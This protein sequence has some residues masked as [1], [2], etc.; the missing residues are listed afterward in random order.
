MFLS[1]AIP[2]RNKIK[3]FTTYDGRVIDIEAGYEHTIFALDD[4]T[5]QGCGSAWNWALGVSSPPPTTNTAYSRPNPYVGWRVNTTF[6]S[7][8]SYYRPTPCSVNP[9]EDYDY[10]DISFSTGD[11]LKID[12][13]KPKQI[14]AGFSNTLI[15]NGNNRVV[16]GCGANDRGQTNP[17]S[18]EVPV[19]TFAP[20]SASN[21]VVLTAVAVETNRHS[22]FL[23]EDGTVLSCGNNANGEL[24]NQYT[25][26]ARSNRLDRVGTLGLG[27]LVDPQQLAI[28]SKGN[29]Y[30][31]DWGDISIKKLTPSGIMY[32]YAGDASLDMSVQTAQVI[33]RTAKRFATPVGLVIDSFDNIYVSEYSGQ[34]IRK[35]TPAGTVSLYAGSAGASGSTDNTNGVF[36]T[37]FTPFHLAMHSSGEIYVADC[38]NQAIRKISLATGVFK[39]AG[40][41]RHSGRTDGSRNDSTFQFP[42]GII[43]DSSENI[44]VADTGNHSIRKITAAGV[45][46]TLAGTSTLSGTQDG[47]GGNARFFNPEGI[48]ID[49]SGNLYVAD[50]GNHT[51]RKITSEGVVTTFA[52]MSGVR[53]YQ[54]GTGSAARF[55]EPRGITIDSA[56]NLYV[57]DGFPSIRKITTTGVVTTLW[58]SSTTIPSKDNNTLTDVT[59]MAAGSAHS[60]FLKADGTVWSCGSN[61]GGQLGV[62]G[63]AGGQVVQVQAATRQLVKPVGIVL[64]EDGCGYVIDQTA[65]KLAKIWTDG[66]M[67]TLADIANPQNICIDL[68][69]TIFVGCSNGVIKRITP[70][71]AVTDIATTNL[72]NIG[73]GAMVVDSSANV[74]YLA[75]DTEHVIRKINGFTGSVEILAGQLNT[76]GST[77]GT[78]TSA[79]FNTPYGLALDENRNLYVGDSGNKMVRKINTST[80]QVTTF[81]SN[82]YYAVNVGP[83]Q[84][85][86]EWFYLTIDKNSLVMTTSRHE[87][88]SSSGLQVR[89][90]TIWEWGLD[91]RYI[92]FGMIPGTARF[93]RPTGITID[94]SSNLYIVEQF[95]NTIRKITPEGAVTTFAGASSTGG[96]DGTGNQA[97]FFNPNGITKDSS[98]NLYIADVNNHAIR[99]ITPAGVVTTFAG[100]V[101][102]GGTRNG[103]GTNARFISPFA[104]VADSSDNIFVCENAV[105]TIRRIT[106]AGVVTTFAGLSGSSGNVVGAGSTARFN[107]PMGI[108]IDSSGNLYVA[109]RTN[110]AIKKI[111]SAGVVS[112][113][114]GS[115]T[116]QTGST[117]GTGSAARFNEPTAIAIDSSGNI[118]VADVQNHT[119]RKI[120]SAGVVTTLAGAVGQKGSVDGTGS[121]ASF[122]FPLGITV[123]S[124]GNLYVSDRDNNLIRKIT[125]TGKVTNFAGNANTTAVTL[126]GTVSSPFPLP[127]YHI[128]VTTNNIYTTSLSKNI[129]T[130]FLGVRVA[131]RNSKW[132]VA[133]PD[134]GEI[135]DPEGVLTVPGRPETTPLSSWGYQTTTP[136]TGVVSIGAGSN[137]SY[138]LK[139]DGVVWSTTTWLDT[140]PF[141]AVPYPALSSTVTMYTNKFTST[142][143]YFLVREN[144][145]IIQKRIGYSNFS[146]FVYSTIPR[147]T[148][149]QRLPLYPHKFV[150]FIGS[151]PILPSS[152]VTVVPPNI[153]MTKMSIGGGHRCILGDINTP[154]GQSVAYKRGFLAIGAMSAFSRGGSISF[155]KI[156]GSP[157]YTATMIN[158]TEGSLAY[159]T[160]LCTAV[161]SVQAL[162]TR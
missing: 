72:G 101:G 82:T 75:S 40:K 97:R 148:D 69:G 44:Y 108:T 117:D 24:G 93:N 14:A 123:D 1:S 71:G 36:A 118:Y 87:R 31:A 136:L 105:H 106:P 6:S 104:L 84:P 94:S 131:A 60:V 13:T 109:D 67:T 8:N 151:T 152:P 68:D 100:M 77:N 160:S 59:A 55:I 70:F 65:G 134:T 78:G 20:L 11:L 139:D 47:T 126:D 49:S 143:S 99:R 29:I 150:P 124:T 81:L 145:Q 98:G 5:V 135:F 22:L 52:G 45:V 113:F 86:Q 91:G 38:T 57:S 90:P 88:L 130:S 25:S 92:D 122:N 107:S 132:V 54:D 137:A 112:H 153:R 128:Y 125:P 146:P 48:T 96:Q 79:R 157:S 28:D 39:Q 27:N 103:T 155:D 121:A 58:K 142:S 119:I 53:G 21:T 85:G 129:D 33:F 41:F 10:F 74:L 66:Q 147:Q 138:F 63:T 127:Y 133:L 116:S 73:L 16:W 15:I 120:T 18:I 26:F 62:A 56:N 140:I 149:V 43:V 144:E 9:R 32:K 50:R 3:A 111:T 115:T 110:H 7:E 17:F 161:S 37:F 102:E 154:A 162:Y 23:Q 95:G 141:R 83:N 61:T 159:G 89:N 156:V 19:K 30:I 12:I 46:S 42:R 76:P 51:I 2:K 35:I 80:K 34:V 64:G 4:G 114:A 158:L